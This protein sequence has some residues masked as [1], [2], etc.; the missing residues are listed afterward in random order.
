MVPFPT[1]DGGLLM[2][3]L[4]PDPTCSNLLKGTQQTTVA[5]SFQGFLW[6]SFKA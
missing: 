1:F 4:I 5:S 3:Y 6:S 2:Y